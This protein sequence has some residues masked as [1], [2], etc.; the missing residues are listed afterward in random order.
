VNAA[1]QIDSPD[2]LELLRT[3]CPERGYQIAVAVGCHALACCN[4]SQSQ[5]PFG[6]LIEELASA[7]AVPAATIGNRLRRIQRRPALISGSFALTGLILKP[8]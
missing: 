8:P 2:S 4:Q 1:A 7:Q 3:G 6:F 5:S